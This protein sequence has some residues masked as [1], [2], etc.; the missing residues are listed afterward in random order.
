[1]KKGGLQKQHSFWDIPCFRI[2]KCWKQ[3]KKMWALGRALGKRRKEKGAQ[4]PVRIP[5][6]WASRHRY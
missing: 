4:I 5:G 1:M 2:Q 3:K 6:L